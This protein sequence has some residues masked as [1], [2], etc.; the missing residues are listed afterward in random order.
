MMA[1]KGSIVSLEEDMARQYV[2]HKDILDT[3]PPPHRFANPTTKKEIVKN[4]ICKIL[5][6]IREAVKNVLAEFVR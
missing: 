2:R 5:S 6:V 4:E 3:L 1:S